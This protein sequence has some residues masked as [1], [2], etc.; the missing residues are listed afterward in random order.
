[1]SG[2]EQKEIV[3]KKMMGVKIDSDLIKRAKIK[4][5]ELDTTLTN[6]IEKALEKFLKET[7]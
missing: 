3:S 5:L 1:M 7:Q 6:I 4:A 2:P